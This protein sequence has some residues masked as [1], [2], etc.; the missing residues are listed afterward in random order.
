MTLREL[1]GALQ[2]LYALAD[3]QELDVT[4]TLD[5][6]EGEYIEKVENYVALIRQISA[7]SVVLKEE[8]DKAREAYDDLAVVCYINSTAEIK[9]W[10]DVS[11]TSANAVKIVKN[12]P[13]K[14]ILFVPDKNLGRYVA[15]QVTDKNV[16]LE[17]L[18]IAIKQFAKRQMT[19]FRRNPDIV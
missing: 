5:L 2:E 8:I 13:N 7:D 9:S 18:A 14:N 4:D 16:M 6:M 17:K 19:W 1:T 10:C 15:A 3:E 11:V 12:L